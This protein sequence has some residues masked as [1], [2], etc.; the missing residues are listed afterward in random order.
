MNGAYADDSLHVT[1]HTSH[2]TRHTSHV[3]PAE[4]GFV[5]VVYILEVAGALALNRDGGIRTW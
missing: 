2:V 4:I 1:R 5:E 3:A